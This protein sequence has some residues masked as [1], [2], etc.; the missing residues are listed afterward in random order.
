MPDLRLTKAEKQRL[1]EKA[2]QDKTSRRD[3]NRQAREARIA[4][5]RR[6]IE[7][8]V[9][10][11]YLPEIRRIVTA[12]MADLEVGQEP[13]LRP[14]ETASPPATVAPV[15]AHDAS[16]PV[17]PPPGTRGLGPAGR[18]QAQ[19]ARR[20][21]R[22]RNAGLTRT[23]F[24]VPVGL[25]ARVTELV[26]QLLK[27]MSQGYHVTIE[28]VPIFID[29]GLPDPLSVSNPSRTVVART[30]DDLVR[31]DVDRNDAEISSLYDDIQAA[32]RLEWEFGKGDEQG[33]Q[34][35]A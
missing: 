10:A 22:Q 30:L 4:Q 17:A 24:D 20:R 15:T 33:S 8:T 9:P 23:T 6:R 1:L 5:G 35:I 3:A 2:L 32:T 14:S 18:K 31:N 28:Q 21:E 29:A 27:W 11:Q 26:D 34:N 7:K 19:T 16:N 13:R 12:V 25:V